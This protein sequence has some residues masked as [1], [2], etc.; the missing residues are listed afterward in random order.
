MT[1]GKPTEP[2]AQEW[3]HWDSCSRTPH[4]IYMR[5]C[6]CVCG[7]IHISVCMHICI[8]KVTLKERPYV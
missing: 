1:E 5:V 2:R 7:Y 8:W 6:V 3:V 4:H